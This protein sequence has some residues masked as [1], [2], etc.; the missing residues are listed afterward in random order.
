MA[1]VS[2]MTMISI[3]KYMGAVYMG[4]KGKLSALP[5]S[6][7]C[8]TNSMRNVSVPR[9]LETVDTSKLVQGFQEV[10]QTDMMSMNDNFH[11]MGESLQ[12]LD[13]CLNKCSMGYGATE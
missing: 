4:S 6:W 12:T 1:S 10:A 7:A 11:L 13:T 5:A 9:C 2:D 8:Y 3:F